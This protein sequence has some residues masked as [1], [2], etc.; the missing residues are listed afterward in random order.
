MG[1]EAKCQ[2][3]EKAETVKAYTSSVSPLSDGVCSTFQTGYF[4]HW[5]PFFRGQNVSEEVRVTGQL[6]VQIEY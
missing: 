1:E 5:D 4:S 3:D 6:G 2:W